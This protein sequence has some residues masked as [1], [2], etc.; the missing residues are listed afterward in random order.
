[1][2]ATENENTTEKLVK[3]STPVEPW[4]PIEESETSES[5]DRYVVEDCPQMAPETPP[6]KV[7]RQTGDTLKTEAPVRTSTPTVSLHVR[8]QPKAQARKRRR[9]HDWHNVHNVV[10]NGSTSALSAFRRSCYYCSQTTPQS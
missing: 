2:L 7:I 8:L 4:T 9:N 5:L 1:M 10:V 6:M 3:P